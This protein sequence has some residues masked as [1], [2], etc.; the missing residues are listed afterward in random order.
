MEDKILDAIR[1]DI[2][3]DIK[4]RVEEAVTEAFERR[5]D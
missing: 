4:K 5:F 3:R 1:I 2:I